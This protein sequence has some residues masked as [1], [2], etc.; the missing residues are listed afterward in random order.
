MGSESG[1]LRRAGGEKERVSQPPTRRGRGGLP[2]SRRERRETRSK[3]R[4]RK[5]GNGGEEKLLRS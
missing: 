5:A 4:G 2:R 3:C 1:E